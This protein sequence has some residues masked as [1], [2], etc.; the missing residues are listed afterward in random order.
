MS[1]LTT[2]QEK[3]DNALGRMSAFTA[4]IHS[5]LFFHG[6]QAQQSRFVSL[7]NAMVDTYLNNLWLEEQFGSV[8]RQTVE[9]LSNDQAP[10]E[11][12]RQIVDVL[13]QRKLIKTPLGVGVWLE[14]MTMAPS[15]K[16]PTGVWVH[17]DP[18]SSKELPLVVKIMRQSTGSTEDIAAETAR[19]RQTGARQVNPSFA[20]ATIIHRLQS[21]KGS[22]HASGGNTSS[23]KC[24]TQMWNDAADSKLTMLGS[25]YANSARKFLRSNSK[26]R[27]KAS[28]I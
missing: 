8:L 26:S 18:L 12:M 24:L 14:I 22:S 25:D 28:W 15:V 5:R 10:D 9:I 6:F 1:E 19:H 21:Q 4:V 2:P 23:R 20:W 16:L 17:Y 27:E 3:R 11:W 7:L 13:I